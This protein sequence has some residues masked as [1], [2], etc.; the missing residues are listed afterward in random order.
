M[1]SPLWISEQEPDAPNIS[2]FG[3]F[4]VL[5][6]GV[7]LGAL[8]FF[9][10]SLLL[11]FRI[12]ERPIFGTGR[13][14][15]P[16][17][18]QSVS[19]VAFLILGMRLEIVGT[20]MRGPGAAVSNHTSWLDIFALNAFDDIFFVA[21]SE[22]ATW[23]VI[24]WLARATGTL[25]IDRDRTQAIKQTK[26]FQDRLKNGHRLLFFP[27]GTSSD[28]MQVLPFKSTLFQSF[29]I[30]ELRDKISIQAITLVFFAP[31]GMDPRFYGW[32]GESNLVQHLVKALA[33]SKQG[34]VRV[35]YH[36][37]VPVIKFLDRKLMAQHM[38]AQVASALPN[39]RRT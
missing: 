1:T 4:R 18:T 10:L 17:I 26:I 14:L 33:L 39:S 8:I 21:K 6:R 34:K 38:Q 30:P 28:G 36:K 3:W 13:P 9:G 25:F 29:F 24:G 19:K 7:L 32:W 16:K 27:E 23:P 20:P 5:T 35:I 2:L 11:I 15:T 12:F 31:E 37:P 22:V